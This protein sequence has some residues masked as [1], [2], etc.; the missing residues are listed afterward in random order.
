MAEPESKRARTRTEDHRKTPPSKA[1]TG[2]G[3]GAAGVH[4]PLEELQETLSSIIETKPEMPPYA[5]S[6][7][8]E[9]ILHEF[10][11][12]MRRWSQKMDKATRDYFD[13]TH[14]GPDPVLHVSFISHDDTSENEPEPYLPKYHDGNLEDREA[15]LENDSRDVTKASAVFIKIDQAAEALLPHSKYVAVLYPVRRVRE[16]I[17]E[18][19]KVTVFINQNNADAKKG[20]LPDM[21]EITGTVVGR[22]S[23]RGNNTVKRFLETHSKEWAQFYAYVSVNPDRT[24]YWAPFHPNP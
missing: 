10:Y 14:K 3:G 12:D 2:G 19:S 24:F 5:Y 11:R 21:F 23:G 1:Y 15:V 22:A 17:E 16:S 4:A 6:I 18:G 20:G 8:Y 7:G 13:R 9:R